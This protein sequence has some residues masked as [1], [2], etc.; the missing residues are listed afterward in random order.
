MKF[1]GYWDYPP[2][3]TQKAIDTW[4][5]SLEKRK[6]HGDKYPKTIFGPFQYNGQTNG[7]TC[8]EVD[9]P[10]QLTYLVTDYIGVLTWEFYPIIE[11]EK[12]AEIFMKHK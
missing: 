9:N 2:E 7:F 12:A 10:E 4:K 6:K 1:I 5:A 3:F 11:N 8:F